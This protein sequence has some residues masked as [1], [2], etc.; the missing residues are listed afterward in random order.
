MEI[1]IIP[2]H[3]FKGIKSGRKMLNNIVL[4]YTSL[5]FSKSD[6]KFPNCIYLVKYSKLEILITSSLTEANNILNS[7]FV[8]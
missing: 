7:V 5:P 8:F 1:G 2:L 3:L 6:L 4:K